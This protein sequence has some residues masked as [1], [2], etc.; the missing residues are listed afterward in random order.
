MKKSQIHK[1]IR[2][3]FVN[4]LREETLITEAFQDPIARMLA[5]DRSLENNWFKFF[6][7]MARSFDIAWDKALMPD[8]VES[9][10]LRI[11]H[12]YFRDRRHLLVRYRT[13]LTYPRS[14]EWV[15]V[16][17]AIV[18]ERKIGNIRLLPG[19]P[20][21]ELCLYNVLIT[22]LPECRTRKKSTINSR[23]VFG[24]PCSY[25]RTH[26]SNIVVDTAN[27]NKRKAATM[28]KRSTQ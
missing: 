27:V 14:H 22:R 9:I 4:I 23:P 15:Y 3:E 7:A 26:I 20:W 19:S 12:G 11:A 10:V 18:K 5:K 1:I 13:V 21:P 28:V 16:S 2:E 8:A 25:H 6:G 17:G 24:R